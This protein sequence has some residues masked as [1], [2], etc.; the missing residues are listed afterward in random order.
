MG[1]IAT[2]IG[3]ALWLPLLLVP[4]LG[5]KESAAVFPLQMLLV[6]LA[7]PARTT[8]AQ[9]GAV[10]ASFLLVA[11]FLAFRAELFGDAWRVYE[12]GAGAPSF[13]RLRDALV[14][15]PAWWAA[16]TRATPRVANV[17]VLLALASAA[18]L[19]ATASRSSARLGLALA[20]ASAG[21]V[22]ATL[23]NLG[24]MGHT[25]EGGRLTYSPI[26]WLALALGVAGAG[27]GITADRRARR[28]WRRPAGL[29]LLALTAFSA[30]GC[31]KASSVVQAAP[32]ATCW[33]LRAR[34]PHGRARIPA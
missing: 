30:R 22:A 14:S 34:F 8:R 12:T 21:L 33:R 28:D 6:A 26:A 27:P 13:E 20:G 2:R 23:L 24:S 29:A 7:W 9:R 11:I 16:L 3:Q 31:W 25:G 5:F 19:I 18:L 4:A 10:A 15:V 17:Y 1:H 32:S